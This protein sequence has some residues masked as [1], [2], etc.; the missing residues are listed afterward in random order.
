VEEVVD[1]D[2]MRRNLLLG[3]AHSTPPPLA[4]NRKGQTIKTVGTCQLESRQGTNE[5]IIQ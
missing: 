1:V 5:R 3:G 2:D 4:G